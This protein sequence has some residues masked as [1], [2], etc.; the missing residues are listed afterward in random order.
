M[1]FQEITS[2]DVEIT[3]HLSD[4]FVSSRVVETR[5]GEP[6]RS[7]WE[8]PIKARFLFAFPLSEIMKTE[9]VSSRYQK[10]K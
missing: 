2:R 8:K 6:E 7:F 9:N 5:I 10:K 4:V 3:S 1:M